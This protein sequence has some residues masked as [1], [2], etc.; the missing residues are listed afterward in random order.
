MKD[1]K[2]LELLKI[3][4]ECVKRNMDGRCD[5]E[6]AR[7]DIVQSSKELIKMYDAVIK[8]YQHS[9]KESEKG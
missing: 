4:R 2:I 1:E 3:E 6:C 9:I 8:N 7:C 5:R